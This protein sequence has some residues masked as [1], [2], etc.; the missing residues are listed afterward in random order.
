MAFGRSQNSLIRARL[1]QNFLEHLACSKHILRRDFD[2][3][4]S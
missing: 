4:F 3:L 2:I 1:F